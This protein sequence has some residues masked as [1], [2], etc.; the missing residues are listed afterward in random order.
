MKKTILVVSLS[1]ALFAGFNS[2]IIADEAP[3]HAVEHVEKAEHGEEHA[4]AEHGEGEHKGAMD[5]L[6]FIIFAMLIGAATRH[7]LRK[8]PLPYTVLLLLISA[9]LG[10][11]GR[12]GAFESWFGID[13]SI[14]ARSMEWAGNI[15]PH[16]ILFIFLPILI[17]EAAFAM[18]VHTFKKSVT[19]ATILAVPGIVIAVVLTG[20]MMMWFKSFGM[21]LSAWGWPMALMFGAVASATDP[22]AVVSLLK[23]LGASKKLGT[24]IEGESLLNDG[25]AIVIFVVFFAIITA[26]GGGVFNTGDALFEFVRVS[27]GG[28]LLGLVIAGITMA[29]VKNVFNDALVEITVIVAAA[30]VTFFVSEEFFKVS[31]VLGLVTM[32]LVMAGVGRTRISPEVEHFLHEFWEMA[33]FIANTL[34]FIIVGVVIAERITFTA[35][36]LVILALLYVGVH[37]IRAIIIA[38]FL[39][40]MQKFGY[41]LSKKDAVV[42]WYGGLRGAIGL[43]LALIVAGAEAI[44][45]GIR[46]EFLFLSSGIVVLTLLINATTIKFLVNWLGITKIPAVKALMTSNALHQLEDETINAFETLKSDRFMGGATWGSVR[47]YLP[48]PDYPEF[49]EKELDSLDATAEARRRILEKEKL[50]YW[51]QF[52]EGLL[53]P[54]AVRKLS[55]GISEVLDEGGAAPLNERNYLE[56]IMGSPGFIGRLQS[57]P[58]LSRIA[59]RGIFNNLSQSYD[60]ARGFVVAQ[61]EVSR[62]V[63]SVVLSHG[64]S[65]LEKIVGQ[66]KGEINENKLRGLTYLKNL[67]TA[68]PEIVNA[69]ETR[70]AIRSVLNYERSAIKNLQNDG[71]IESDD[72]EKMIADVEGRMKKLLDA[73]PKLELPEPEEMLRESSWLKDID[74]N[75][76][77][78]VVD[79]VQHKHFASGEDLVKQ[80]DPGDGMFV[81]VRGMVKVVVGEGIVVDILG[82]GAIIGEMAVLANVPRTATLHAE[83]PVTA[84][85]MTSASLQKLM[86]ESPTLEN[87]LWRTAGLRFAENLLGT[88]KPYI[89]WS[90]MHFRKWLSEGEVAQYTGASKIDLKGKVVILIFGSATHYDTKKVV[91]A[92][93]ALENPSE[94]TLDP[95]SWIY[96]HGIGD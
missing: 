6:F 69:I 92:P 79:S 31:G 10:I 46:N 94:Y 7:F 4:D 80:G 12:Y 86:K 77:K 60:V 17:F 84:L 18:D 11:L 67:R 28:I 19:N 48:H 1:L 22:V 89:D 44:P 93:C 16:A 88:Q 20:A 95:N 52:K 29:W 70:Q 82:R 3:E 14:I 51:G 42:V 38:G 61:E 23:E 91:K 39:P 64:G 90:Q 8:T 35:G 78:K 76:F 83:T 37:I 75:T 41:G 54:I 56:K 59:Q 33:A 73:P 24:L 57:V 13:V 81:L 66:I 65:K 36:G 96:L 45:L 53:G 32:G 40:L 25:T 9:G 71:R 30:Y 34:I 85:W 72:A 27:F 50:S 26:A 5:P 55:D 47:E 74:E 87:S 63:D 43:A 2:L 68:Y 49:S 58:G 15:N 21:G 62:F